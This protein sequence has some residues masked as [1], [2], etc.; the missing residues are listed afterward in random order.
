MIEAGN[1]AVKSLAGP[2]GYLQPG[3]PRPQPGIFHP[4]FDRGHPVGSSF[5]AD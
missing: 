1:F 3:S 4:V 2:A 5:G